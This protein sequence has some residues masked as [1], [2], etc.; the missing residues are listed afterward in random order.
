[1]VSLFEYE[2][3]RIWMPFSEAGQIY[4]VSLIFALIFFQRIDFVVKP[5]W[6]QRYN[7]HTSKCV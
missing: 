4:W 2:L 3:R 1:M 7:W 5:R 6:K